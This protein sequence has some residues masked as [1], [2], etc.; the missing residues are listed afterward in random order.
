MPGGSGSTG[1]RTKWLHSAISTTGS[2]RVC[3]VDD[4]DA[5]SDMVEEDAPGNCPLTVGISCVLVVLSH[6]IRTICF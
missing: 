6:R 3:A 2:K 1:R 5:S 4:V